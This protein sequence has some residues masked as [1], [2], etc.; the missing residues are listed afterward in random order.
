MTA[1]QTADNAATRELLDQVT[2]KLQETGLPESQLLPGALEYLDKIIY[3]Q[4]NTYGFQDGITFITAVF[5]FAVIPAWILKQ[6]R[7]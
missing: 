2:R 6:K 5:V 4:A 7:V 3:A 1:T